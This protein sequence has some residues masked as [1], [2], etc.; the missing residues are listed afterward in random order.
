MG[1]YGITPDVEILL[2][3]LKLPMGALTFLLLGEPGSNGKFQLSLEISGEGG[4][5]VPRTSRGPGPMEIAESER[6]YA[7][8]VGLAGLRFP[9][10]GRYSLKLF[11]DDALHFEGSFVVRQ[12]APGDFTSL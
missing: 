2:Q 7:L 9:A 6:R 5:V 10:P 1:F 11:V 3:D 12:G 8:I 4:T